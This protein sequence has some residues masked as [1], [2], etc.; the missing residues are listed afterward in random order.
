MPRPKKTAAEILA[1][2]EKILDVTAAILRED[3]PDAI[4]SWAIAKRL[5]MSHMSL[6]TYFEN[7]ADI[8]AA[9]RERV[10]TEVRASLDAIV[11]RAQTEDIPALVQEVWALFL[12]FALE[13]PFLH[14]LA[15]VTREAESIDAI[16]NNQHRF[17]MV[18]QLAGI[19]KI[20]MERDDFEPR[21]PLLAAV[22][23]VGI[24]NIPFVLYHTGKL[25]D[26]SLRDRVVDEVL[27]AAML[28]L[29]G[30]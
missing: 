3:G 4:A 11:E 23:V 17:D 25:P 16:A 20:G 22:T 19:L 7:Q 28:Y 29:K 13:Q 2:R 15:W 26:L 8:R 24:I 1:M 9:L 12:T 10:V 27:S 21:D 18:Y 14:R 5:G 30:K 6:F